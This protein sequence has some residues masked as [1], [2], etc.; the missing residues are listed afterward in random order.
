MKCDYDDDAKNNNFIAYIVSKYEPTIVI[1]KI[2]TVTTITPFGLF[3]SDLKIGINS[4]PWQY[5][6]HDS[7]Q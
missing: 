7:V 3:I 4:V 2:T 1:A 5:C 6:G